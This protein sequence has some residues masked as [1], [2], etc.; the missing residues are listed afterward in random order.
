MGEELVRYRDQLVLASEDTQ[1]SYDRTVITL[2]AGALG[3]SFALVKTLAEQGSVSH[4]LLLFASWLAWGVSLVSMLF[5]FFF[6]QKALRAAIKK[7]DEDKEDPLP[8]GNWATATDAANYVGGLSFLGGVVLFG[9]F[10]WN[11]GGING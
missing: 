11:I 2:S 8:G 6:S 10:L 4:S 3:V 9:I 7:V 1:R 5:S